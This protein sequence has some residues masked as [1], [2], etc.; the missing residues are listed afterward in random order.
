MATVRGL[1]PRGRSRARA[2]AKA[3]RSAGWKAEGRGLQAPAGDVVQS[4]VRRAGCGRGRTLPGGACNGRSRPP[5]PGLRSVPCRAG[6]RSAH[7]LVAFR[8]R[9]PRRPTAVGAR[10][11][12]RSP[13]TGHANTSRPRGLRRRTG[14]GRRAVVAH[15]VQPTARRHRVREAGLCDCPVWQTPQRCRQ[16][17]NNQRRPAPAQPQ[18]QQAHDFPKSRHPGR[19]DAWGRF[20]PRIRPRESTQRRQHG[21]HRQQRRRQAQGALVEQEGREGCEQREPKRAA[22]IAQAEGFRGLERQHA[23]QQ[24]AGGIAADAGHRRGHRD[25]GGDPEQDPQQCGQRPGA[26]RR[27]SQRRC[28]EAEA[29]ASGSCISSGSRQ[30][31]A[32]AGRGGGWRQACAAPSRS[33]RSLR[34][35]HRQRA[36]ALVA[37]QRPS[38][39]AIGAVPGRRRA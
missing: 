7:G 19:A 14:R 25:D 11:R 3:G 16:P 29:S 5:G 37:I 21:N 15:E 34:G 38:P 9:R 13:S 18:P 30:I 35:H 12:R 28:A 24:A 17:G 31:A 2:C 10:S 1:N 33:C 32:A 4:C 26:M 36:Q 27:R 22:A 20:D 6:S 8:P 39:S 23:S